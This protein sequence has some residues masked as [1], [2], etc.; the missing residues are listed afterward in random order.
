MN[1]SARTLAAAVLAW[2]ALATMATAKLWMVERLRGQ[3]MVQVD[4]QWRDLARGDIVDDSSPIKSLDGSRVTYVRGVRALVTINEIDRRN[5]TVTIT[6]PQGNTRTVEVR[7]A[8]MREFVKRLKIGDQV[9][10]AIVEGV[11]IDVVR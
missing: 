4:G 3:A 7:S 1:L 9:Q 11:T 8:K 10:L 6:G 5:N 2:L